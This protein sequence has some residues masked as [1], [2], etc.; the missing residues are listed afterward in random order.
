MTESTQS[1][2]GDGDP[3][4]LLRQGRPPG[5]S[6]RDRLDADLHREQMR[7]RFAGTPAE[8]VLF[9][10]WR[11][12][13]K[14]GQGGMG[15]VYLAL[16]PA[17]GRRVALKLIDRDPGAPR[18]DAARE[19]RA[20]AALHHPNVVQVF[21]VDD[22]SPGALVIEMEYVEGTTLRP[23]ASTPGRTWRDLTHA[24]LDAGE[25][26]TALHRAGLIHRDI[27]PDNILVG[28]DGEVKL[29]D[30]GLAVAA[31][32][33]ATAAASP[34]GS[35][36]LAAPAPANAT[37]LDAA[38]AVRLTATGALLGTHGY[39]AP[40]V[41]AGAAA[42][43][44][45]DLFGLASALFHALFGALPYQGETPPDLADA[46]RHGHLHI[47]PG[48]PPCP[49]WLL[50]A[51]RRAL[52]ADP[53]AR[54][55]LPEFLGDLRRG[56]ARRR[57]LLILAA[58]L[59]AGLSLSFL[60]YALRTPPPDPCADAGAPMAA[61]LAPP[62]LGAGGHEADL[63]GATLRARRD[64]WIDADAR[65]CAARRR[66]P[67]L[68]LRAHLRHTRERLCLDDT[69]ATFTALAEP[70]RARPSGPHLP[71]DLLQA[72]VA[73]PTC[74]EPALTHWRPLPDPELR[75][76]LDRA[77]V[78]QLEGRYDTAADLARRVADR[79]DLPP[80]HRAEAYYRLGSL[81]TDQRR[82]A[83]A[84][85]ALDRARDL[86]FASAHDQLYC[87]AIVLQAKLQALV[88]L[89]PERARLDLQLAEACHLR[90][91]ERAPLLVGDLLEARGLLAAAAGDSTAAAAHHREALAIRRRTLGDRHLDVTKSLHNLAGASEPTEA[92][93]LLDQALALRVDLLGPQS[94]LVADILVDRAA[95]H[96]DADRD[97]QARADFDRALAI[98]A[99]AAGDHRI[100]QAK[101][102]TA[103]A[104]LALRSHDADR[105]ADHLAHARAAHQSPELPKRHPDR[106]RRL[107]TEALLAAR[108]PDL[109]A[110]ERL[111][112][113]A[114]A[115][116]RP[117]AFS[118][119]ALELL[120]DW[121]EAAV[122][123]GKL[124][125]V[126]VDVTDA[127]TGLQQHLGAHPD[128]ARRGVIA[129]YA[130]DALLKHGRPADAIPYLRLALD[131]Y[132]AL[133]EPSAEDLAAR[134]ELRWELARHLGPDA[135]PDARDLALA[136]RAGYRALARPADAAAIDRW[137]R[138][139]PLLDAPSTHN[140]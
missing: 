31:D 85:A 130:A 94:P 38:L 48:A 135:R 35:A 10:R 78:L 132:E 87:R 128:P 114:L 99:A 11:V 103:L 91:T 30:L 21:S 51:L 107:Q 5:P 39:I 81:L 44:Q 57:R 32:R 123:A 24:V 40:E 65:L 84:A 139:H 134:A 47:P 25:G 83:A 137:L 6:E 14:L 118:P 18:A 7:E 124:A 12:L 126:A 122:S 82:A 37:A 92:V 9:R 129:W 63:L 49:S 121:I 140:P 13:K 33:P 26:L 45:S 111:Y 54:A 27:K 77:L 101:I 46:L 66:R 29:A 4:D 42:T 108:R 53:A 125:Q 3:A 71:T 120:P 67:L 100:S 41:L 104:L 127:G 86:A 115:L 112:A 116:L 60:G 97:T 22:T 109:P 102:H 136:A 119:D 110:A 106:I 58:L 56:L 74:Q 72:I 93:S 2:H 19:A 138:A 68:D 70:L 131:A 113:E 90:L 64:A 98:F 61:L 15:A 88:V 89:D 34:P 16:D 79:D 73:I 105:A 1:P 59:T 80:F 133:P 95:L 20:L 75:R 17:L 62:L 23:W 43:A 52:A 55:T 36:G 8:P 96:A 76:D 117:R 50:A 28:P 69:L